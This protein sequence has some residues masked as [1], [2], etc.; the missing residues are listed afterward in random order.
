MAG[1][2]RREKSPCFLPPQPQAVDKQVQRLQDQVAAL[3]AAAA[4][5]KGNEFLG[6]TGAGRGKG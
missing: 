2:V 4:A 5:R 6:K 3:K 1:A